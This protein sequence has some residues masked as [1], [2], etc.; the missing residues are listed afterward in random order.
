MADLVTKDDL[1]GPASLA[2]VSFV[3]HQDVASIVPTQG[4]AELIGKCGGIAAHLN[5][6]GAAGAFDD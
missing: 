2:N 6:G 5:L 3:S 4:A 1:G